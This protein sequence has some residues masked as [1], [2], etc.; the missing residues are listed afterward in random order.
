MKLSKMILSSI[1][2]ASVLASCQKTSDNNIDPKKDQIEKTSTDSIPM[3][4]Q[5]PGW[6]CLACGM[7]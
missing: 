5:F 2:T 7:G 3:V 1:L 6:N 4:K